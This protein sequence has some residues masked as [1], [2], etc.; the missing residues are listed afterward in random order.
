M[1]KIFLLCTFVTSAV[2]LTAC[3]DSDNNL[4]RDLDPE[5]RAYIKDVAVNDE[6]LDGELENKTIKWLSTWDI[7]PDG[8]GKNVPIDLAVF[9]ERYGGEVKYYP[10]SYDERY[11]KLAQYINSGEGID[12]FSGSDM[13]AF[14]KGAIKEMFVPVDDYIDFSSSIW[15]DVKDVN[16]SF[17]WNDKHYMTAVSVSGDGCAVIYNK[18]TIAEMGFE[19]PAVLLEKGQWTWDT[20]EQM[21]DSFVDNDNQ[22][23]GIDGWW[24]EGAFVQTTGTPAIGLENGKLVNNLAEPSIERVQN[25]LYKLSLNGSVAIGSKTYGWTEHPE[26][27]GEGKLLFYP[28]GLWKLYSAP[29]NWKT[30][31][32]E[33]IGFVPMPKD[34][35]ADNYYIPT[36]I[37]SY[38]FVKNGDNPEGVA[39]YLDCKRYVICN[40][41]LRDMYDAQTRNDFGWSDEMLEMKEKMN[42]IALENPSFDF[43]K[44]ASFDIGEMVDEGLRQSAYGT[45]WSET[46][47]SI[48][49]AVQTLIDEI[50]EK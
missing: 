50:N 20:F 19:D 14:P 44:G 39:K 49:P 40:Q 8:T 36:G 13:D 41:N 34:P 28:C 29:E 21:L 27:I 25:W 45:P 23:Y 18:N 35:Q 42:K 6:L 4:L 11:E 16:D 22:K 47:N 31:F 3:G 33:D 9:Q 12:F 1:K 43:S 2:M 15:E 46:F 24:F 37:D 7:N 32:G 38:L 26:Y 5:T 48:Y 17:I 30:V 10:V